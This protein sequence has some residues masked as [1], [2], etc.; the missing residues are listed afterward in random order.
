MLNAAWDLFFFAVAL[1]VLVTV[2]EAGHFFAARACGVTV[3]RF[4][5]GFGKVLFKRTGRD[6][7]EYAISAIPLGGYVKMLGENKDETGS[8]SFRSKSLSRRA[9]II[10]AGPGCNIILAFVL[11]CAVN[12]IGFEAPR[13]IIGDVIPGSAAAQAGIEPYSEIKS[14]DGEDIGIW[15][16]ASLLAFQAAGSG[17][18]LEVETAPW[19]GRGKAGT[20]SIRVPA[21]DPSSQVDPMEL[22]GLRRYQGDIPNEVMQVQPGSPAEGA[23][24]RKGDIVKAVNGHDTPTWYRVLDAIRAN[25]PAP[26]DLTVERG[27][28]LY[29]C[30]LTPRMAYSKALRREV[31]LAGIAVGSDGESYRETFRDLSY[32]LGK[33]ISKGFSD[34]V[35]MSHLVISAAIKMVSGAISPD[36]VSGPI[37]I[38]KG[39]GQSAAVGAVFFL[40]F[41]AAISVNL[42]IL[43]LL[44]IPV[45]DGGQLLF[46]AYEAVSGRAPGPRVQYA[47]TLLGFSILL[48]LMMLAVFNDIRGL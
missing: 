32:P 48:M 38:A 43:N 21:A 40:S 19:K 41:L 14:I 13:P 22:A 29:D 17:R 15:G 42:G 23:G 3:Q 34:T 18:G 4:S 37:A 20:Y 10:A 24:I 46:M 26:L 36:N 30:R 33:S 28:K 1:G 8:G 16:D 35:R 6:G 12:L 7:C 47:L 44:P 25:G 5:I 9:F 45:L 27:G 11:Y 31:P 2:H 39:A